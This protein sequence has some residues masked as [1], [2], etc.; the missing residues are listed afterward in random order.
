[1]GAMRNIH[2]NTEAALVT[3]DLFDAMAKVNE[4]REQNKRLREALIHAEMYI[5][6][7]YAALN[8]DIERSPVLQKI[9]AANDEAQP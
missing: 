1:M 4:L 7:V 5:V 6:A 2:F 3:S 8:G 9:R